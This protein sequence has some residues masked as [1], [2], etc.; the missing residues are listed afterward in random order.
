MGANEWG[1]R[2]LIPDFSEANATIY[3]LNASSGKIA[4]SYFL[5]RIA[6]R[7]WLS[8]SNGVVYAGALDGYIHA[9]DGKTGE[10]IYALNVGQSLYES[11]TIGSTLSGATLLL[12]LTSPPSYGAF[13]GNET[14]YLFAFGVPQANEGIVS[15]ALYGAIGG[16][17]AVVA[18]L[19]FL[20]RLRGLEGNRRAADP[21]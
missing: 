1:V 10:Q 13:S 12:Q 15:Y 3:G 11:P 17:A 16:I 5:P 6:Y 19:I 14:G 18:V 21:R 2:Q 7:G 20:R 8:V 4:W 9:L